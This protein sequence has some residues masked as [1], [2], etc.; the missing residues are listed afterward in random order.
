MKKMVFFLILVL[1]FAL[2]GCDPNEPSI[3]DSKDFQ[4][5]YTTVE[6]DVVKVTVI[7]YD[8]V[9]ISSFFYYVDSEYDGLAGNADICVKC[10]RNSFAV[11]MESPLGGSSGWYPT[12]KFSGTPVVSGA[13]YTFEFPLS[14]LNPVFNPSFDFNY[15][16]YS[17]E[18]LD[19][20]PDIT[21]SP[22][23]IAVSY[24]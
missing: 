4:V 6:D 21:A 20:L 7:F 12:L 16:L 2:A 3:P 1:L 5:G 23:S 8:D 19:R 10:Y 14:C 17:M 22:N 24:P 18:S 11:Y 9:G 13:N 15:W